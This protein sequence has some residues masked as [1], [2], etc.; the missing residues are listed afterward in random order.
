MDEVIKC[1]GGVLRFEI[2]KIPRGFSFRVQK[3]QDFVLDFIQ[4]Q[5]CMHKPFVVRSSGPFEA[6]M[7][8]LFSLFL[9]SSLSAKSIPVFGLRFD[10]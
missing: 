10:I 6:G 7:A 9:P 4:T 8:Y 1:N 3:S 2:L 5:V